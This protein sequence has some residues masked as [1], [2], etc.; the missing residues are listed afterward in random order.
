MCNSLVPYVRITAERSRLVFGAIVHVYHQLES[1]VGYICIDIY[2]YIYITIYIYNHT[3]MHTYI[4]INPI[5]WG[6]V[7]HPLS[8][9]F[10]M[11]YTFFPDSRIPTRGWTTSRPFWP[12]FDHGC[13]RRVEVPK[14]CRILRSGATNLW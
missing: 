9:G 13:W 3:Y 5:K 6:M 2:V 12:C 7:M 1:G 8:L 14:V 10:I 11:I 4:H